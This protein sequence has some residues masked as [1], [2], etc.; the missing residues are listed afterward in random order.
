MW[1]FHFPSVW[2]PLQIG[3]EDPVDPTLCSNSVQQEL[4]GIHKGNHSMGW[5][6]TQERNKHQTCYADWAVGL[7]AR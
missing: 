2:D 7:Q 4:E 6:F 5:T 3:E 1:A